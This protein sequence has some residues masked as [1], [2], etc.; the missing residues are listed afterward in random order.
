MADDKIISRVRA[1]VALE[2]DV[3]LCLGLSLEEVGLYTLLRV[4]TDGYTVELSLTQLQGFTD[5]SLNTLRNLLK[6]L[7]AKGLLVEDDYT[8]ATMKAGQP[9]TWALLEPPLPTEDAPHLEL[10]ATRA[11]AIK[12]KGNRLSPLEIAVG[13]VLWGFGDKP[14]EYTAIP[15]IRGLLKSLLPVLQFELTPA[16][17]ADF[18]AWW[19]REYPHYDLPRAKDKVL[20]HLGEFMKARATPPVPADWYAAY[21][22]AKGLSYEEAMKVS[23]LRIKQ[24]LGAK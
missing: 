15:R 10:L 1:R 3:V 23:I 22:A 21:A 5:L 18:G 14:I 7:K 16:L 12:P 13:Q 17:V 6:G 24:E 20:W 2:H 11:K 4:L 9:K 8:E 19:R